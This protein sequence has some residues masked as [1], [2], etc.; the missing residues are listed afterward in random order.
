MLKGC[1]GT[2]GTQGHLTQDLDLS[3]ACISVEY[4]SIK[5]KVLNYYWVCQDKRKAVDLT[6]NVSFIWAELRLG[7]TAPPWG[8]L[9]AV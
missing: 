1:C 6:V 7:R 4:V 3:T 8:R 2:S 9:G 5:Y